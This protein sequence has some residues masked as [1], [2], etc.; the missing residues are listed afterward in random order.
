M[1]D[2]VGLKA[3]SCLADFLDAYCFGA[4][5]S[6]LQRGGIVG[7]GGER[8]CRISCGHLNIDVLEDM[9]RGDAENA[10][11]GFDEVVTFSSAMLAAEVI[12][13][14]ERGSELLGLD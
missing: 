9:A 5:D 8:R 2:G 7:E 13:E 14:A 4:Q 11:V 3:E 1:N 12:G 10:F 6:I